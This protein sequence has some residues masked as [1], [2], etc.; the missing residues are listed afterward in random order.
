M[1]N[2]ERVHSM[3][4]G[5]KTKSGKRECERK[6]YWRPQA[7]RRVSLNC[8]GH[9]PQ[10]YLFA[11]DARGE[12]PCVIETIHHEIKKSYAHFSQSPHQY[13]RLERLIKKW[14]ASDLLRELSHLIEVRFVAFGHCC[15]I[16]LL[17]RPTGYC[18]CIEGR[19][20]RNGN[21]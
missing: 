11:G 12:V 1:R 13:R 2:D 21:H 18:R 20:Q 14:G 16:K 9:R 17:S 3:A 4:K 5:I 10:F 6:G 19:A 8:M 15:L 7:R